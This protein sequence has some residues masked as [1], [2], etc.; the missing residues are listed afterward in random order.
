MEHFWTAEGWSRSDATHGWGA[1]SRT[2]RAFLVFCKRIVT[3]G[4][5]NLT[6]QSHGTG[7]IGSERGWWQIRLISFA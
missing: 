1:Q 7:L 4:I 3:E 6:P 2:W 5:S